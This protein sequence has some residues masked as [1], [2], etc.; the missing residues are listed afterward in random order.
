MLGSECLGKKP[1]GCILCPTHRGN[2][3]QLGVPG[4][5]PGRP[6]MVKHAASATAATPLLG[7]LE[8]FLHPGEFMTTSRWWQLKNICWEFSPRSLRENHDPI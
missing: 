4:V 5:Q 1:L 8:Q 2:R 3:A 6:G 7:A